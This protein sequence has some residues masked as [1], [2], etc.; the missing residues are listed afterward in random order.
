M[1]VDMDYENELEHFRAQLRQNADPERA[2]NEKAYLKSQ[3]QFYGVKVP[4]LRKI[5]KV[6]LKQHKQA[7]VTDIAEMAACL[8]DSDWHEERSLATM[9]LQYRSADLT[10]AQMPVIEKMMN[11]ATGW[12]HLDALATWVVGALIDHD[13]STL[14]YLPIWAESG[15]F[16]VRR[17]AILAQILQFRRGEG[18]FDLFAR[19]AVP[20]FDEGRTWTKDE[21]FFIRKAIGWALR[22]L[23]PSQ[24]ALVQGFC[25]AAS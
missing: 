14:R 11:E 2:T 17:A 7:P 9:L 4:T 22:E 10:L 13:A 3:Q 18:D 5:A 16:W 24:P 21:R 8:W 23:A 25:Q 15:N 12:V 6:W 1:S 19:L 20:M